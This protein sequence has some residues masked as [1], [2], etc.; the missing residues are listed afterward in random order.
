MSEQKSNPLVTLMRKAAGLPTG[1]SSCC[2]SQVPA[3]M[4]PVAE[5]P[6]TAP[7]PK[8]TEESGSCCGKSDRCC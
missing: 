8:E 2:G 7:A 4:V 1:T 5:T 3:N 6:A